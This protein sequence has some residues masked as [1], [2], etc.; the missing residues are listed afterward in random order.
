MIEMES[1]PFDVVVLLLN[2]RETSVLDWLPA[3]QARGEEQLASVNLYD[4]STEELVASE[5]FAFNLEE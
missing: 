4:E 3:A 1:V 2:L 5:R